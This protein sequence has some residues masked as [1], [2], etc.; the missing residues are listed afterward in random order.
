MNQPV[1]SVWY[2]N[3]RVTNIEFPNAMMASYEANAKRL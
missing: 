2:I 1:R 3:S